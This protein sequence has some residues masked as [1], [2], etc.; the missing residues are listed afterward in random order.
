M[1]EITRQWLKYAESDLETAKIM[2][3]YKKTIT[4]CLSFAS[5]YRKVF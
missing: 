1:K 5:G 4:N 3:D 2:L